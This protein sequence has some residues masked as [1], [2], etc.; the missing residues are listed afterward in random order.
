[1]SQ[2]KNWCF[3]LNNYTPE[4]EE[5]LN[6]LSNNNRV[7]YL[8]YGRELAPET[9]TPHLQGYVELSGRLRLRT[10]KRL[11]GG[12]GRAHFEAAKGSGD[13]NRAYCIKDGNFVEHGSPTAAG[14]GRR[15]DISAVREIAKTTGSMR[16]VV[17]VAASYQSVRMAES[18]LKYHEAARGWKPEVHWFHG[19]TGTGKSRAAQALAPGAFWKSPGVRW[20]DGYDAHEDVVLDD[21]RPDWFSFSYLLQLLDR[22]PMYV[23]TK[24]GGR[25]FLAKRIIITAPVAPDVMFCGS[26]KEDDIN[27]LLRRIDFITPF[28]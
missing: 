26:T 22:Y 13:Q 9:G 27:Q 14:Q 19:P 21:L 11:F 24:G 10:L 2:S 6:G 8:V 23:E 4:D 25:Q 12:V 3:T 5:I 1:M 20:F 15:S 17:E 28:V 7:G 18:Y 16:K